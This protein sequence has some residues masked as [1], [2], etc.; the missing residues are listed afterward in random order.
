[1]SFKDKV[2]SE[3]GNEGYR[4]L[5]GDTNFDNVPIEI[6]ELWYAH[7]PNDISIFNLGGNPNASDEE[8]E[9]LYYLLEKE[10]SKL[11]KKNS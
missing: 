1:M 5:T 3:F 7:S 9:K 11:K 2:T 6:R 8:W 4:R 10:F